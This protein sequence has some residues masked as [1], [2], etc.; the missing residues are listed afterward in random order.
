M[1]KVYGASD[2]IVVIEDSDGT[3]H[4]IA[5]DYGVSAV[6]IGFE[7]DTYIRIGYGKGSKGIWWIE[8]GETGSATYKLTQCDDEDA[9]IY[10]DVFE[11]AS[12]AVGWGYD[13]M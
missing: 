3:R 7:D 2:D 11:I 12:E 9:E 10:S 5:F 6:A 13:Y 4:E 1:S 8:I